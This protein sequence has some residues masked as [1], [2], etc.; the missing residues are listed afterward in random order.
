MI[1]VFGNLRKS[2]DIFGK[3]LLPS[4]IFRK[5]SEIFGKSSKTSISVCLYSKQHN[6]WLLVD[7]EYLFSCSTLCLMGSC[8]YGRN[9]SWLAYI[10]WARVDMEYLFS[11]CS[12]LC[13]TSERSE[14]VRYRV[15]HSVASWLVRSTPERALRVR[16]LAGDIV[17]CSWARH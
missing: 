13:L 5:W 11:S 3:V 2:S 8:R 16:A 14:R 10:S 6:T 17:L 12:T 9:I 15:L 4:E 7:M 1:E